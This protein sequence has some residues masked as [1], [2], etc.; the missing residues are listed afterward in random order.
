M[1]TVGLTGWG[2][3]I[4]GVAPRQVRVGA[5]ETAGPNDL[6]SEFTTPMGRHNVTPSIF[7][8][9]AGVFRWGSARFVPEGGLEVDYHC[10]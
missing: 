4:V 9:S 7:P 6:A 3:V 1:K 5:E 2:L 8:I 10:L